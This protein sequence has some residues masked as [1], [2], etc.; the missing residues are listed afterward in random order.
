MP[1]VTTTWSSP[2]RLD[3]AAATRSSTASASRTSRP[4]ERP[5]TTARAPSRTASSAIARPIPF[6]PPTTRMRA[7]SRP[8]MAGTSAGESVRIWSIRSAMTRSI[9]VVILR[10][11]SSPGDSQDPGAR[12]V[13]EDQAAVVRRGQVA[14]GRRR[15]V[16]LRQDGHAEDLW[17]LAA[18]VAAAVGDLDHLAVFDD[19]EGVRAG[20][21]GVRGVRAPI[22]DR[23]DRSP[24]HVERHQRPDG[25]VHEDDVVRRRSRAPAGRCAC[26]RCASSHR[27]RRCAGSTA[28][29][30]RVRARSPRSN[31][32][33]RRSPGRRSRPRRPCGCSGGGSARLRGGRTASASP[34]RIGPRRRRPGGSHGL[35]SGS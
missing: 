18:P 15:L 3:A 8:P 29:P 21:D 35:A 1:A 10:F 11:T 14:G 16:G 12:D 26:S 27:P 17:R 34:R 9:R 19:D 5:S 13:S 2:P 20:D 30:R 31:P 22:G 7:R 6:V 25:V 24:D 4:V 32:D 28:R 23:G 33:A